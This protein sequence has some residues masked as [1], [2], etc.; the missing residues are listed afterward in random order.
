MKG[1]GPIDQNCEIACFINSIGIVRSSPPI[2]RSIHS[3]T[4]PAPVCR[5]RQHWF[6]NRIGVT[7]DHG[8][9]HIR[10]RT[11]DK[12]CPSKL[13]SRSSLIRLTAD[14]PLILSIGIH[15]MSLHQ[16]R[17]V[18]D[19]ANSLPLLSGAVQSGKQNRYKNCNYSNN[20]KKF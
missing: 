18:V 15:E 4:S 11:H 14:H 13:R 2:F 10:K 7:A 19:T 5:I 1:A 9:L 6:Q 8:L 20:D 3:I 17:Q 16:L 12:I